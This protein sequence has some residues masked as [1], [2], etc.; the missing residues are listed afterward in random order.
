VHELKGGPGFPLQEH[1]VTKA[2]CENLGFPDGGLLSVIEERFI[3]K[4]ITYFICYE[5]EDEQGNNC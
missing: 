3:K 4:H 1:P 2:R 5:Y